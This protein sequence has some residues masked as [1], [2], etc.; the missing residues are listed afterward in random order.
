MRALVRALPDD[1]VPDVV[2]ALGYLDDVLL[3]A[4]LLDGPLSF[5][6]RRLVLRYWPGSAGVLDRLAG[7]ARFLAAWVPRRRKA[8]IFA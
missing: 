6:D 1:L 2:P 8:R 3:A 5:V 7:T 4:A